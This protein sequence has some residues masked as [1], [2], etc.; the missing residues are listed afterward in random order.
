MFRVFFKSTGVI[1]IDCAYRG[2][3]IDNIYYIENCLKPVVKA[4]KIDRPECG[5]KSI[6]ILH[7]NARPHI[8][9]NVDN[10]FKIEWYHQNS[11]ST[12]I[13]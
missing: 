13:T 6:K 10:F 1:H 12:V 11:T 4:L 2:E 3:K 9:K 5:A 7:D 8:H